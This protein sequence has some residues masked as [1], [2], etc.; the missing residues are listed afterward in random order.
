LVDPSA[1][2]RWTQAG[3]QPP[4]HIWRSLQWYLALQSHLPGLTPQHFLGSTQLKVDTETKDQVEGFKIL[5]ARQSEQLRSQRAMTWGLA[6][7]VLLQ[8]V[9][10]VGWGR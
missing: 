9:F 3:A 6:F 4:P 5:L 8:F 7:L 10:F 2:T 1:W